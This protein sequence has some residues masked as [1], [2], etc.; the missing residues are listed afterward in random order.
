LQRT[1]TRNAPCF[2]P[3]AAAEP[4]GPE[5]A[6]LRRR[7]A[8]TT[9]APRRAWRPVAAVAVTTIAV[10]AGL[11]LLPADHA[12]APRGGSAAALLHAAAA[13]AAEQ[14][15]PAGP[16]RYTRIRETAVYRYADGDRRAASHHA[17]VLENWVGARWSGRTVAAAGRAW[18][19][20]DAALA[21]ARD[22]F[23][24]GADPIDKP[25]DTAYAYGDGP[26]ADLDPAD[27]PAGRDAIGAALREKIQDGRPADGSRDSFVAYSIINLLV[28]AR[29]EPAQRAALLDVLATDPHAQ[30]LGTVTDSEHR[31]GRGVRLSY[32]GP[33]P[34]LGVGAFT[35]V[36]D[37]GTSEVLEWSLQPPAGADARGTALD[38]TETVLTA[39]FAPAVGARP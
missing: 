24:T 1:A 8:T 38:R 3:L 29:L 25:R 11:A 28:A 9:P 12:G 19:T 26:L 20:G 39:G 36:F 27:L 6:A 7:L 2:A 34:F 32:A 10:G 18:T 30:D 16:L 22:P 4:A 21:A 37:P 13:T 5:R 33:Q 17:Q 35:V 23:G 31:E 14:P 15:V